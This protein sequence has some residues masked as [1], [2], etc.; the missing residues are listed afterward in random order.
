MLVIPVLGCAHRKPWT[1]LANQTDELQVKKSGA[2]LKKQVSKMAQ[3][4]PSGLRA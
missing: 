2:R 4:V 1:L 3:L